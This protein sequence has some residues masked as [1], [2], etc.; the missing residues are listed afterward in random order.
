MSKS[1]K[2]IIVI[3]VLA[4]LTGA[5]LLFSK[6]SG[7]EE[8]SRSESQLFESFDLLSLFKEKTKKKPNKSF[9]LDT[10]LFSDP[11]YGKLRHDFP[12]D[13]ENLKPGKTDPFRE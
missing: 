6:N 8:G 9:K 5:Y 13:A 3:V 7:A 12:L 11:K 1:I 4:A 10:E 2:A